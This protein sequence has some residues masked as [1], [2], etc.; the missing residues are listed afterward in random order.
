[1]RLGQVGLDLLG[2]L[3]ERA[4]RAEGGS[5]GGG[6]RSE[7]AGGLR[8]AVRVVLV[9]EPRAVGME[10]FGGGRSG[11]IRVGR[12]SRR[13]CLQSAA[14]PVLLFT[15]VECD[16]KGTLLLLA[17]LGI[18]GAVALIQRVLKGTVRF[19]KTRHHIASVADRSV[20]MGRVVGRGDRGRFRGC[21]IR[22]HSRGR[23]RPVPALAIHLLAPD[24]NPRAFG[25]G[26]AFSEIE[27][28]AVGFDRRSRGRRGFLRSRERRGGLRLRFFLR[29][30]LQETVFGGASGVAP[31][32]ILIR[33]RARRD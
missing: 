24:D 20:F 1:M 25:L 15:E 21:G 29:L 8:L 9:Y 10:G 11:Y 17:T 2:E 12:A 33:F 30:L 23:R 19:Q 6:R 28:F 3:T 22:R 13:C 31:V 16:G 18:L 5:C 32:R 27:S 26:H 14:L 7:R 4:G